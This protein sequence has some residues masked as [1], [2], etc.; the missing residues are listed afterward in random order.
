MTDFEWTRIVTIV[1][2]TISIIQFLAFWKRTRE[3]GVFAPV[4]WLSLI[5]IY[6]IF[7]FIVDGDP[8]YYTLSV[9]WNNGIF[10]Y[11]I[12]LLIIGGYIFKD[13]KEWTYKR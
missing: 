11:G 10:I 1:L 13:I 7:K 8:R 6:D 9:I 12:V 2:A 4:S 5:V 3:P